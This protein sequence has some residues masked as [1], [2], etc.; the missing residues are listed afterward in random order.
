MRPQID[1]TAEQSKRISL[2]LNAKNIDDK[3]KF[4]MLTAI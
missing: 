1:L 4:I 3:T 2:I